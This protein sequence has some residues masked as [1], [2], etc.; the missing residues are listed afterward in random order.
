MNYLEVVRGG[1]KLL[2]LLEDGGHG[3]EMAKNNDFDTNFW[4]QRASETRL[5]FPGL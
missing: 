4:W 3:E 1:E 5:V 2:E